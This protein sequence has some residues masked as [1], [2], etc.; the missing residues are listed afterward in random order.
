MS[1]AFDHDPLVGTVLAERYRIQSL[2]GRGGCGQVYLAEHVTI[3]RTL[4]VKV[5]TR[6]QPGLA[7]ETS[8]RRFLQEA[9]A[10]SK[11]NHPHVIDIIDFGYTPGGLA[12]YVMEFLSGEDLAALLR[13]EGA[14]GWP[15]LG[16][17]LLQI[18]S[19]LA[20]AHRHGIIHRDIKPANCFRITVEDDP[21]FIKVLDFGI[22]K[23]QTPREQASDLP[24]TASHV[25]LGTPAYMAPELASGG[26]ATV[27][28]DVYALGILMYELSTGK[29]PF[30]GANFLETFFQH[31]YSAPLAPS[32]IVPA[33]AGEVERIILKAISKDPEA[34][35]ADMRELHADIKASLTIAPVAAPLVI[36]PP[37]EFVNAVT[38]VMP[39]K[40]DEVR[41]AEPAR[42]PETAALKPR[43]A[44]AVVALQPP[45]VTLV[46]ERRQV[47]RHAAVT[48][49]LLTSMTVV[50][51]LVQPW[52]SAEDPT[53][54]PATKLEPAKLE[55]AK[56]EP[57]KL[58]PAKTEPPK[59]EPPKTDPP[60][61]AASEKKVVPDK[62]VVLDKKSA[63]D[64]KAAPVKPD[65]PEKKVAPVKPEPVKAPEPNKPPAP[66]TV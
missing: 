25:L 48:A 13:R 61:T 8:H 1:F 18:C 14:L 40:A 39:M 44:A 3:D 42:A 21:D 28:S 4:A 19:A 34:R 58:E 50:L 20:A 45:T 66:S 35:Y 23:L 56:Q 2:L 52:R 60:V 54:E 32:S 53:D 47:R 29:R 24:Q 7:D 5:M 37:A 10:T 15:R 27:Q 63:P 51:A 16:P 12:Y 6:E 9:R 22:A 43:P 36:V 59:L 64:K 62:K 11:L 46:R 38:A 33:L 55:P 31:T 30:A 17:M 65:V 41:I 26:V 57:V 49:F